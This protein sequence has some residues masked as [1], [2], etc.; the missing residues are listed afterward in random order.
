MIVEKAR[1]IIKKAQPY[2]IAL[3]AALLATAIIGWGTLFRV[4]K[5]AQD[6]LYQHPGVTSGDIVIIGIDDEALDILGPYNTWDRNVMASVLEALAA[7]PENKP[8]VTAID[9]LYA[10]NTS[11]EADDRLAKAAAELGNVVTAC[12][13]Q[14]GTSITWENGRAVDKNDAAV[15]GFEQPYDALRSVTTQGHSNAMTDTDGVMRHALL[16]VEPE[17]GRT[18]SMAHEAARLFLEKQGKTLRDP[19]VG[20]TGLRADEDTNNAKFGWKS[21]EN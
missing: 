21:L 7:D 8:A 2:L 17:E 18:Y 6:W 4:D 3:A 14:F 10:G 20:G 1:S 9:V 11:P 13:A 15:I 16:Y 5:W 19:A 12:M